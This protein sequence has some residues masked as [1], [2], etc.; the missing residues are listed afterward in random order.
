MRRGARVVQREAG[1]SSQKAF[2][3][4][5]AAEGGQT[6]P[7]A[8]SPRAMSRS[9]GASRTARSAGVTMEPAAI[10]WQLAFAPLEEHVA[11][12]WVDARWREH[13][14]VAALGELLRSAA[15][16]ARLAL[17]GGYELADCGAPVQ[18]TLGRDRKGLR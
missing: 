11:E 3:A 6:P 1:A 16:T 13:P 4:A 15:F 9:R 12:V 5:V 10:R 17:V 8:R 18:P 2:V 7:P 14:A